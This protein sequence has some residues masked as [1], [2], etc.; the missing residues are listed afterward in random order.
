MHATT[1]LKQPPQERLVAS[2]GAATMVGLLGYMLITGLSADIQKHVEQTLVLLNL[3]E[4]PPPPPIHPKAKVEPREAKASGAASPRNL[5]QKAT[6][7]VAPKPPVRLP[8]PPP[9]VSAPVANHGAAA[10]SGASNVRGPG[11]GAGGEGD[12]P[13][14]GGY[15]DGEGDGGEPPRHIAGE[16]KMKY[17]P[18]EL[19][20]YGVNR[21]VGVEYHVTARG[22]VDA[23]RVTIRSGSAGLD[24]LTC[25][26]IE[27]R[28][29]F[30]PS[31][32]AEGRPVG[33][34]MDEDHTWTF[35]AKRTTD[36]P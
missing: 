3:R 14:N 33:S 23:C 21:R 28:F 7:V 10:A 17:V 12:G 19:M 1:T 29:R 16:L 20:E 4:P 22:D 27:E 25:Q 31:R 24:Q 2:A 8:P 30:R 35:D 15:G 32:D 6:E 11:E 13:G 5:R 36:R 9:V 18:P 34:F 26:L